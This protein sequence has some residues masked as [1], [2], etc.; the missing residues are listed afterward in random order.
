MRHPRQLLREVGFGGFVRFNLFVGGTP[1]LAVLNP[2]SWLLL[3]MWFTLQPHFIQQIMPAPVYYAGLLGWLAGNF[4]YYYLNLMTAYEMRRGARVPGGPGAAGVLGDDGHR[5]HQGVDPADLQPELLGEDHPRPDQSR[6]AMTGAVM[7]GPIELSV[8][9]PCLDEAET[10][11]VCVSSAVR[12]MGER[13]IA[14]EVIVADNGSTDGSQRLARN[15]GARVVTIAQRGY[16]AAIIGGIHAARGR[17]VLMAD[18]D[19][20]YDLGNMVPFVES[21][22]AGNEL[23]MGNRFQGGIEPGA[24]PWLHKI[25]N[26]VLS[27]IGKL[28]FNVPIGDFHCGIRAFPPGSGLLGLGLHTTG[29]EFASEVVVQSAM[30]GLRIAE[31]PTRVAQG[32]PQPPAASAHLARRLAAPAIPVVV[33]PGLALPCSRRT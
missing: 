20:S 18:A 22:R 24:M 27:G 23:V 3:V 6:G 29:M 31:V 2:I 14:G 5:R 12:H 30:S 21:L 8:V 28:F 10:V 32:R 15:A 33:Q 16:G 4:T 9:L 13:G 7:S 26:P 17:Y 1:L 25:G 11:A 19:D